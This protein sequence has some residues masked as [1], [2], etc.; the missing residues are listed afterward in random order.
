[1]MGD[2]VEPRRNFIE[3]NALRAGNIDI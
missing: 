2:E 3:G 1:L